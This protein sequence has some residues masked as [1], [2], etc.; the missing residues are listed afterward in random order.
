M[1]GLKSN[2]NPFKISQKPSELYLMRLNDL[3]TALINPLANITL[4][5]N[6]FVTLYIKKGWP[7]AVIRSYIDPF[8]VYI[9]IVGIQ[10]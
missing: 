8:I 2:L 4:Q 3:N 10:S 9:G 1:I 7:G 6:D 5:N